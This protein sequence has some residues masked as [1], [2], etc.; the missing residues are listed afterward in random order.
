MDRRSRSD[1]GI[2]PLRIYISRLTGV[3]AQRL[4]FSDFS[5]IGEIPCVRSSLLAGIASGVG[6]GVIRGVS[7]RESACGD[8]ASGS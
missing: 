4:S 2:P 8:I 3:G 5:R 1:K 6:V 7:T